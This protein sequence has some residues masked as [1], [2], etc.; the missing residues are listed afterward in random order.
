MYRGLLLTQDYV[1]IS[2]QRTSS[3]GMSCSSSSTDSCDDSV[4]A[5]AE[6][7]C[8]KLL[9]YLD[10][11]WNN[12]MRCVVLPACVSVLLNVPSQMEG[13]HVEAV[14]WDERRATDVKA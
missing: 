1:A 7:L 14:L 9:A 10:A 12:F 3:V 5:N 4:C 2:F 13:G 8:W 11:G 6:E